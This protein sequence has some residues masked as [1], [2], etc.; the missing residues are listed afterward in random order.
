MKPTR[1]G[2]FPVESPEWL[3]QRRAGIGGSDVAPILGLS[4][5]KSAF[6]LWHEKTGGITD[7]PSD[8]EIMRWGSTLEPII[9]AHWRSQHPEYGT[10]NWQ[11]STWA[12]P[13]DPW[14]HA[15]PD[16]IATNPARNGHEIVEIKNVAYPDDWGPSGSTEVP[17]WYLTQLLWYLDVLGVRFGWLAI[18]I[19]GREYREYRFDAHDYTDDL[20]LIRAATAEFWTSVQSGQPPALD[21]ST[22]TYQ[23][24]R[25]LHPNI[26]DETFDVPLGAAAF[27]AA[28]KENLTAAEN[29]HRKALARLAQLMGEAR[30]GL[31]DGTKFC[32]RQARK[33]TSGEWGI[34]YLVLA[35]NAQTVVTNT[36]QTVVT[37]TKEPAA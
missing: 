23:T 27:V 14:R 30:T 6:T 36:V 9:L 19:G 24:V 20:R 17:P 29:I 16:F 25:E 34:P 21:G 10:A 32:T 28:A 4:P 15:N 11:G 8:V 2:A 37:N 12:H 22:S 13:T 35:R 33:N 3:A 31:V 26:V 5:F 1:L 7:T 18:L